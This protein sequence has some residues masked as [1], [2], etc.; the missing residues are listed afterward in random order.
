MPQKTGSKDLRGMGPAFL[1]PAPA[2]RPLRPGR[3]TALFS[4]EKKVSF[5]Y[6]LYW[7]AYA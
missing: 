2:R 6:I 3:Q 1:N 4:G 7:R 5:M